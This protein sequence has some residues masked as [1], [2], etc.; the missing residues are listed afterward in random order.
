M[1]ELPLIPLVKG[2]STRLMHSA[3]PC[4]PTV[5][6]RPPG[7]LQ[8]RIARLL[9]RLATRLE[10]GLSTQPGDGRTAQSAVCVR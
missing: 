10:Q 2:A 3:L 8:L 9:H 6:E 7:R 1:Q 5:P 4:S